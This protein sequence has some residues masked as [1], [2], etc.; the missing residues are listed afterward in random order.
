M[1]VYLRRLLFDTI[2]EEI[3]INVH[4]SWVENP[5]QI[6]VRIPPHSNL[7]DQWILLELPKEVW[8]KGYRIE[9]NSKTVTWPKPVPACVTSHKSQRPGIP[10]PICRQIIMLE[11]VLPRQLS[12]SEPLP[13]SLGPS[14]LQESW[15][16]CFLRVSRLV[17]NFPR[18]IP[19]QLRLSGSSS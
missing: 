8:K 18:R 1:H 12:W 4:S 7:R 6:K 17:W 5:L 15:L 10:R 3:W 9:K 11:T 13:G 2:S 14:F 16:I 19:R